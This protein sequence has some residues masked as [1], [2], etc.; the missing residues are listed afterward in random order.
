MST[1]RS[2][3]YSGTRGSRT[4]AKQRSERGKGFT[5]YPSALEH[6]NTGVFHMTLNKHGKGNVSYT[7]RLFAGGHGE[8][9][10]K[11]LDKYG[12][13]YNTVLTYSNGVRVGN[14]PSHKEPLKQKGIGQSWFPKE[15]N[16]KMIKKAG[17]Y[18]ANLKRNRNVADGIAVFGTYRGVRVGIK[19]TNGEIATVFPDSDQ[20]K[21]LNSK[22]RKK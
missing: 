22:A 9:G 3:R 19:K 2:G 6:A 8:D 14:V 10:R 15:W 13:Q 4:S 7:P 5:V 12:I 21:A 18:V 1:G 20:S 16:Q 11:L 17:E